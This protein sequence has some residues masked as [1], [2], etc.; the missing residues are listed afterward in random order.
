M[1][2]PLKDESRALGQP[3]P[4]PKWEARR[5]T[6]IWFD[7]KFVFEIHFRPDLTHAQQVIG[8]R[9]IE[10]L[11]NSAGWGP[12]MMMGDNPLYPIR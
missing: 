1:S 5:D 4:P 10:R 9:N 6:Q 2:R 7:G 3:K 8:A 12:K 11:L